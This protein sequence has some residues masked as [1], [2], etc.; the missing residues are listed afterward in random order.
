M[1]TLRSI[2]T[3]VLVLG[4]LVS[5]GKRTKSTQSSVGGSGIC[6]NNQLAQ[7]N[8]YLDPAEEKPGFFRLTLETIAAAQA[9]GEL[10]TVTLANKN[11]QTETV[12][13]SKRLVVGEVL[14]EDY[15]TQTDLDLYNLVLVTPYKSGQSS[16]L[17]AESD[18]REVVCNMPRNGVNTAAQ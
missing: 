13:P 3:L 18:G 17:S 7:F 6:F 4:L 9:G 5:C 1:N 8:I 12:V 15:L 10:V 2:T 16:V 14:Y 11:L